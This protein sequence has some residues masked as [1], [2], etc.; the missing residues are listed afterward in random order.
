MPHLVMAKTP[1][2]LFIIDEDS[3]EYKENEEE[4]NVRADGK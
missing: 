2:L 1:H 3:A 4:I